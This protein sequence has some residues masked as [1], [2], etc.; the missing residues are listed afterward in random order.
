MKQIREIL[1][2]LLFTKRCRLCGEVIAPDETYCEACLKAEKPLGTLCHKCGLPQQYCT[3][4]LDKFSPAYKG[5]CAPYYFSGSVRTAVY[6]FKNQGYT[7]LADAFAQAIVK[8]VNERYP[9]LHFDAVTYV[10]MTRFR[11]WKRGYNQSAMLAKKVAA[12]LNIPCEAMLRKNRNTH[13]Q[14]KLTA[15]QRKVNLYGAFDVLPDAKVKDKTVLVV[16]DVKTTGST[17][18]ELSAVLKSEGAIPYAAAFAVV[19]RKKN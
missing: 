15:R 10:P 14:R 1:S 5:F 7:E 17:L 2:V 19:C 11:K 13:S 16:D 18:S 8:T 4:S 9:E 3:C 12:L 6:R